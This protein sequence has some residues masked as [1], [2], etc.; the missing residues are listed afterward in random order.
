MAENSAKRVIRYFVLKLKSFFLSKDVLSFLVFLLLSAAFW[1]VNA[2]NKERELSLNIPIVYT[3]IPD[4]ISLYDE[5]PASVNVKVKDLGKT[6]WNYIANS[7]TE[8]I[9]RVNQNFKES[10][11]LNI[12]NSEL[13][14]AISQKLYPS[15]VIL[16]V[17]PEKIVAKYAAMHT[18]LV[19]VKLNTEIVTAN[20][21]QLCNA[22]EYFPAVVEVF[23][24]KSILDTLSFVPTELLKVE[25]LNNSRSYNIKLKDINSLRY[26]VNVISVML[27]AEMFT[28]KSA[29]LLVHIINMPENISVKTFP[30]NVKAT[31]N[32][33]VSHFK[34]FDKD[35]IQIVFDYN[36]VKNEDRSRN[37]LKIINHKEFISNV[38]IQPEEVEFIFEKKAFGER[39]SH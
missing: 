6:L 28:E 7:P 21:H 27:C 32:I 13:I 29:D 33:R 38:R 3:G 18:R 4:N 23:G 20:Q 8:I 15:S 12:S 5:I 16:S 19:P 1:F 24:P 36:D 26:S 25:G 22:P 34:S 14:S 2:L 35:D 11:L 9:I 10:G 30:A 17:K 37:R 39:V 31:F